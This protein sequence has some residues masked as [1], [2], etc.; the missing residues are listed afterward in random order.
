MRIA[1]KN[2]VVTGVGQRRNSARLD[3]K[4]RGNDTDAT[5]DAYSEEVDNA[6]AFLK[7]ARSTVT[8]AET[9]YIDSLDV[10]DVPNTGTEVPYNEVVP[11]HAVIYGAR[12]RENEFVCE[13]GSAIVITEAEGETRMS[14][15]GAT[16]LTKDDR[17]G[18]R[19]RDAEE[20]AGM[21]QEP[22]TAVTERARA[23]ADHRSERTPRRRRRR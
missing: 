4:R 23:Q 13:D 19:R 3:A 1:T 18:V 7:A 20:T 21:A 10:E 22:G 2:N 16:E 11:A 12:P 5:H 9:A 6:L 17:E 8:D 15:R 14:L